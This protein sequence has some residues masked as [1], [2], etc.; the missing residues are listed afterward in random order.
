MKI[1]RQPED[2]RVEERLEPGG[3]WAPARAW[4]PATPWAL[5]RLEKRSMTT[6]RAAVALARRLGA[7]AG[8]VA[9]GGLKDRHAVAVQHV[10]VRVR[11][12]ASASALPS[13]VDAGAGEGAWSAH[14]IGFVGREA[15]AAMIAGNRFG[16][17]LRGLTDAEAAR[18]EGG[19]R[20][21]CVEGDPLDEARRGTLRLLNLFGRQRFVSAAHGRGFAGRALLE[22]RFDRALRLLIATPVRGATG[23]RGR[24]LRACA[25]AWPCDPP[26]P[27][28]HV[29][30][31]RAWGRWLQI[32]PGL[33]RVPERRAAEVI[34]RAVAAGVGAGEGAG[35]GAARCGG[36]AMGVFREA[37]MALPHL[38]RQMAVEAYQSWLWNRAATLLAA[39]EGAPSDGA[40]AG[41]ETPGVTRL[42]GV[43]MP[44]PWPGLAR[45]PGGLRDRGVWGWAM[46]R[47]LEGQGL[48]PEGLV[49]PGVRRPAFREAWRALV[50]EA[51][52][53]W[54][55]PVR[56]DELAA[57]G[58]TA[59]WARTIEFE[60][61]RG[62]YA[63]TVLEALTAGPEGVGA[64][65]TAA[66][67]GLDALD[68]L[69]DAED[70]DDQP[71]QPPEDPAST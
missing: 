64:D 49:I 41:V 42:A 21:W 66:L 17:V 31:R 12:P 29:D 33:P 25:D 57:R 14:L 67:D 54:L 20:R 56:R 35:E 28:E 39:T 26:R 16:L 52:S 44:M 50:V 37:F 36:L 15:S 61:P 22:G 38:T 70:T 59:A 7:P 3:G 60:L 68:A 11:T 5:Y 46:Q 8:A 10:S 19:V 6:P 51:R 34:A 63:T 18:L 65:S 40:G 9:W 55:G 71:H 1:R 53:C 62:A 24:L 32:V 13:R 47:V 48:R 4:S 23:G 2:F 58:S 45:G 30:P 27:G 43:A 69:A